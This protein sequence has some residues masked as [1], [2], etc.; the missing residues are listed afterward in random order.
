MFGFFLPSIQTFPYNYERA[1][2]IETDETN[3]RPGREERQ[4]L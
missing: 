1:I 3:T 2:L 4:Q